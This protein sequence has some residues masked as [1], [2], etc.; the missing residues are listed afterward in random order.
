M[1][2]LK[3]E[4]PQ[5]AVLVGSSAVWSPQWCKLDLGNSHDDSESSGPINPSWMSSVAGESASPRIRA[6]EAT[7]TPR[8]KLA[9]EEAGDRHFS[10]NLG[11]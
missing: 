6:L 2:K 7:I 11:I 5:I 8:G 9:H 1:G 10:K 4:N 3:E